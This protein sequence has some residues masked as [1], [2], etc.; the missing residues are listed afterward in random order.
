MADK[1]GSDNV[2]VYTRFFETC[3]RECDGDKADCADIIIRMMTKGDQPREPE[4]PK[5]TVKVA[6][7]DCV[8]VEWNTD[9]PF[10]DPEE[11]LDPRVRKWREIFRQRYNFNKTHKPK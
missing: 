6:G 5:E 10:L 8:P 9:E 7:I 2:Q 3:W 4:P 1:L 11:Y